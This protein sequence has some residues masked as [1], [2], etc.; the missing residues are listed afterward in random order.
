M[1][2][3]C[4]DEEEFKRAF[5]RELEDRKRLK[6]LLVESNAVLSGVLFKVSF[7]GLRKDVFQALNSRKK[8]GF[9]I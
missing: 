3:G 6:K 8:R 1:C 2:Y 5:K 4:V 9:V 7:L